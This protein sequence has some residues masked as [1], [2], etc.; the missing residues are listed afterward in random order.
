M[1]NGLT[2][3]VFFIASIYGIY[4][5]RYRIMNNVLGNSQIR[6]WVIVL[7]MN[8]PF[9]RNRMMNQAFR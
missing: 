2:R 3:L 1:I 9:L 7:G 8:I 4:K 5:Y 6:K